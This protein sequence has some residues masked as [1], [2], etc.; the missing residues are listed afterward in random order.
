MFY[1]CFKQPGPPVSAVHNNKKPRTTYCVTSGCIVA[2]SKQHKQQPL[3]CQTIYTGNYRHTKQ[4]KRDSIQQ[5]K[6]CRSLVLCIEI[7]FLIKKKG[8]TGV[9]FFGWT[10]CVCVITIIIITYRQPMALLL[11]QFTR[12]L[13]SHF[14]KAVDTGISTAYRFL[15]V[16]A[17]ID[18]GMEFF[19]PVTRNLVS[20][21]SRNVLASRCQLRISSCPPCGRS[22]LTL[23]RHIFF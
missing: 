8:K 23:G 16:R 19:D 4:H 3:N 21:V 12:I 14:F 18:I 17:C 1:F 7:V 10:L 11:V 13:L 9:L 15:R 6:K 5:S 2:A 22:L 20:R